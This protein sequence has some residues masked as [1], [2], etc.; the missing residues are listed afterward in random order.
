[1]GSQMLLGADFFRSQRIYFSHDQ[2]KVYVSYQ[3]G[4]VFAAPEAKP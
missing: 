4:P 3:G 1:M 2:R